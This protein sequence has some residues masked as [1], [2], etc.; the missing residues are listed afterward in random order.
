MVSLT[1]TDST[2]HTSTVTQRVVVAA[3]HASLT[4]PTAGQTNV[5][6]Y[7]ALSWAAPGRAISC[8]SAPNLATEAC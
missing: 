1:V 2:G 3:V 8:G 7:F 4:Y 5:S 6:T